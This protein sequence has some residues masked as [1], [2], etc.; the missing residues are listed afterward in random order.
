MK[1]VQLMTEEII[2]REK[3]RAESEKDRKRP[4]EVAAVARTCSWRT[5]PPHC[6]RVDD[7]AGKGGS[8]KGT[9]TGKADRLSFLCG[10]KKQVQHT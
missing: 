10:Q 8:R 4:D 5:T 2:L 9:G 6:V 1:T 7:V 3:D